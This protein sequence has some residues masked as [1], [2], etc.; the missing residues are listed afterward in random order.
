M[1]IGKMPFSKKP[2]LCP[3]CLGLA[4]SS[5]AVL[6]KQRPD[7]NPAPP[8]EL[9]AR[10]S[11][12]CRRHRSREASRDGCFETLGRLQGR[13]PAR[14]AG[15]CGAGC[16]CSLVPGLSA[17]A[18]DRSGA[19]LQ[20]NHGKVLGGFAGEG[21]SKLHAVCFY[22]QAQELG[23]EERDQSKASVEEEQSKRTEAAE[24]YGTNGQSS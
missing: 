8:G 21:A 13:R 1:W 24:R 3:E 23:E 14:A 10:A 16:G 18:L 4:G 6:K 15:C 7:R 17:E 22:L 19:A 20:Q 5:S 12:L 2:N 11:R 9:S